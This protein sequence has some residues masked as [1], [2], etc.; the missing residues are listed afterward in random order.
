MP[1]RH[2][3]HPKIYALIIARHETWYTLCLNEVRTDTRYSM[4]YKDQASKLNGELFARCTTLGASLLGQH[5]KKLPLPSL[6]HI[7][8]SLLKGTL[9]VCFLDLDP[10]P[11]LIHQRMLFCLYLESR[12]RQIKFV[13]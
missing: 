1:A 5:R 3:S 10:K 8:Y 2:P 6:L 11:F 12:K 13:H 4:H 9:S 7:S